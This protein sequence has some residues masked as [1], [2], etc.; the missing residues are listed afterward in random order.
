MLKYIPPHLFFLHMY[1]YMYIYIHIYTYIYIIKGSLV[2]KLPGY[3][4]LS[5]PAFSPAWQPHHHVNIVYICQS[6]C[7]P[8]HHGNHIII[9]YSKRSGTREFR[10]ENTLGR[11]TLCFSGKVAALVAQGG[12]LFPRCTARSGKVVDKKCSRTVAIARFHIKIVQNLGS[13]CTF[14]RWGRQ[15]VHDTVGGAPFHRRKFRS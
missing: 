14:G 1:M 15:K 11:E 13:R 8:H 7:Q 3:G 2:R 10:L 6:S 4:R 12:S 9:K 5:W